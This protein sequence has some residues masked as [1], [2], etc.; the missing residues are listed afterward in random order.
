M[1]VMYG[2]KDYRD[3]QTQYW[4][5]LADLDISAVEHAVTEATKR[6]GVGNC[7]F[8]PLPGVL[9]EFASAFYR[10]STTAPFCPRCDGTGLVRCEPGMDL[11]RRLY[12]PDATA[13]AAQPTVRRCECRS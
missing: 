12:G 6:A 11:V 10:T 7:R 8:F 9:R 4:R 1:A 5:A 2:L 13:D 3:R